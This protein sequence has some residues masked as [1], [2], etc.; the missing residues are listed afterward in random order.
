F[1][2]TDPETDDDLDLDDDEAPC[3]PGYRT[4]PFQMEE[5]VSENV[6]SCDEGIDQNESTSSEG[7]SVGDTEET[8]AIEL[9]QEKSAASGISQEEVIPH[10]PNSIILDDEKIQAIREAMSGFTLPSP[11]EWANLD[12]VKL[13]EIINEKIT[14][15]LSCHKQQ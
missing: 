13:N 4:L 5:R 3:Y 6:T 8:P 2:D 15:Q 1:P 10:Q 12:T 11:P 9:L 7:V 14:P